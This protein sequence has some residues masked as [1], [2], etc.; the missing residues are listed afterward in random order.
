MTR[1]VVWNC[2]GLMVKGNNHTIVRNTVFD[3]DPLNF[4]R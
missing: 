3:T 1:N 4:E 2:N